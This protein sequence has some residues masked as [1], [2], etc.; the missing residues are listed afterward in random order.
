MIFNH[1]T[2]CN[3]KRLHPSLLAD[4][5]PRNPSGSCMI[6]FPP[7]PPVLLLFE[8]A[9][10]IWKSKKQ[11]CLEHI[12]KLELY[13]CNTYRI[14]LAGRDCSGCHPPDPLQGQLQS[15]TRLPR[16]L[17]SE[18]LNFLRWIKHTSKS[19]L[20]QTPGITLWNR[21]KL[22]KNWIGDGIFKDFLSCGLA[23]TSLNTPVH[24]FKIRDMLSSQAA[25]FLIRMAH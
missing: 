7:L 1:F 3:H 10:G 5:A 22:K 17:P 19:H 9:V 13:G 24:S 23:L 8:K 12:F 6:L 14:I 16:A 11:C 15:D 2:V 21:A 20:T 4:R 25:H 18:V